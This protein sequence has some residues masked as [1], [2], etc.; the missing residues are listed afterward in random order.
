MKS[1]NGRPFL[2]ILAKTEIIDSLTKDRALYKFLSKD[3]VFDFGFRDSVK[4]I[5]VADE[6]VFLIIFADRDASDEWKDFIQ[7]NRHSERLCIIRDSSQL[8]GTAGTDKINLP[9]LTTFIS[10]KLEKLKG[11]FPQ[12]NTQPA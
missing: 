7:A 6:K 5:C 9:L 4:N 10:N 3:R 2:A 8:T 11:K 12:L 1:H